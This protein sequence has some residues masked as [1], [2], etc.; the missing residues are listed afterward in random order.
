MS[1]TDRRR[2]SY[3]FGHHRKALA[4]I[5]SGEHGPLSKG[6]D[7]SAASAATHGQLTPVGSL[8]SPSNG[9]QGSYFPEQTESE[10]S[11][12]FR[13]TTGRAYSSNSPDFNEYEN[14]NRR[15]SAASAATISSQGSKSSANRF[16]KQLQGIFN[17]ETSDGHSQRNSPG[18]LPGRGPRTNSTSRG[19]KGSTQSVNQN[20]RTSSPNPSRPLTPLP[21]SDVT[22]WEY[23]NFKVNIVRSRS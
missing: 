4:K 1:P 6:R 7:S 22:P 23:Q 13:P 18:R 8:N 9:Y 2:R 11:P 14:S 12:S 17:E 3:G 20:D 21:S 19:R 5:D 10:H 15:P 16:Q